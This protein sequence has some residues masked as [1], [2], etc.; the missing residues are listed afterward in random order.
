MN[1]NEKN[2]KTLKLFTTRM[3]QMILQFTEMKSEN[4][5]LCV[6]VAERDARIKELEAQLTQAKSN[7]ESLKMAKMI[8]ISDRDLDGAQKRLAKLIRD[9]NKCI[10]LLSEK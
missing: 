3:R 7:Y 6:Q 1:A 8:E 9:V 10:T 5:G 4:A 2:E